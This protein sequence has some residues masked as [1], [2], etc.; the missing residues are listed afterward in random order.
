MRGLEL[1]HVKFID[2]Y[3]DIICEEY[4][5][6]PETTIP[7]SIALVKNPIDDHFTEHMDKYCIYMYFSDD[8]NCWRIIQ[9]NIHVYSEAT[10][11]K[12]ID[13]IE[14]Y[15]GQKNGRAK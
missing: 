10:I 8:K 1:H 2:K 12:V 9:F 15:Q 11:S 3:V 5:D 14:K 6:L 7:G 13:T 4:K